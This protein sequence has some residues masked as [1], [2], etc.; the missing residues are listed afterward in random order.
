MDIPDHET[1]DGYRIA[2]DNFVH[3]SDSTVAALEE[4]CNWYAGSPEVIQYYSNEFEQTLR[5]VEQ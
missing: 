3:C 2:Y 5:M 4:I 1:I